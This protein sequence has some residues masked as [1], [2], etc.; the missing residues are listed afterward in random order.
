MEQTGSTPHNTPHTGHGSGNG[1][2]S[3]TGGAVRAVSGIAEVTTSS[4][5]ALGG[6]AVGGLVGGVRGA[7]GGVA[8]GT[9]RGL[10][11]GSHSTPAAVLTM[12]AAGA[13][14][15]VEWPVVLTVGGAALVLRQ[16]HE[17]GAPTDGSRADEAGAQDDSAAK[18]SASRP[19]GR[20]T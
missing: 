7:V 2:M 5:G 14:G 16:L 3:L 18:S 1:S 19:P 8:G 15:L 11:R 20:A 6:A 17:R 10:E 9:R 12:A 4:I 13:V